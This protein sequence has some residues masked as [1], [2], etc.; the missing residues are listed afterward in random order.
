MQ[1]WRAKDVRTGDAKIPAIHFWPRWRAAESFG[2]QQKVNKLLPIIFSLSL[3]VFTAAWMNKVPGQFTDH[4]AMYLSARSQSRAW[5]WMLSAMQVSAESESPEKRDLDPSW[6]DKKK[7]CL[8]KD[9]VWGS[10]RPFC[11]C[12]SEMSLQNGAKPGMNFMW[13]IFTLPFYVLSWYSWVTISAKHEMWHG[14]FP[15]FSS[16]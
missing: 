12:P 5:Q 14:P 2:G 7:V 16:Q 8:R 10:A 6:K 11:R 15:I 3:S 9:L 4:G 1:P 13:I